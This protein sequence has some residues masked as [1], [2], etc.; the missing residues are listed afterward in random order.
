VWVVHDAENI[1][2]RVDNGGGYESGG[3]PFVTGKYS[4][5]PIDS[6]F[7]TVARTSSTCQ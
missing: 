5:A 2:E 4:S 6:S 1:P 7:S 3:P